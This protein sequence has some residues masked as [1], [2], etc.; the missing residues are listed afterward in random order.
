MPIQNHRSAQPAKAPSVTG[1]AAIPWWIRIVV[2]LGALLTATGAVIALVDPAM[3][4]SP[5]DTINGAVHIYAGYL[6]SRNFALAM[7]LIALL[8]L[9]AKRALSNLMV[10]VALVQFLDAAMD[11][12]EG[13]W[14]IAPG[15]LVFGLVF[16]VGAAK[17]SR[18]P[19]W[20]RES[21]EQ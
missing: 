14:M 9:G 6:A 13:R 17:L 11:C 18:Y 12:A 15:V 2:C 3:L 19:I 5:G 7:L 21:W 1:G 10:L 8:V 4:V 20:R 16:L